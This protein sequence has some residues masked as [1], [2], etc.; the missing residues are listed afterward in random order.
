MKFKS[1]IEMKVNSNH[2]QPT[3]PSLRCS[4]YHGDSI[5]KS[6]IGLLSI[7]VM[8]VPTEYKSKESGTNIAFLKYEIE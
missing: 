3:M 7:I 8:E 5:P 4:E 2:K 6:P 1:G